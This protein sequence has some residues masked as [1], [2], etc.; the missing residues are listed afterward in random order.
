MRSGSFLPVDI[1]EKQSSDDFFVMRELQDVMN[2]SVM[3]RNETAAEPHA[4]G[5]VHHRRYGGHAR[6]FQFLRIPDRLLRLA[7]QRLIGC[8]DDEHASALDE[9]AVTAF[10]CE[11]VAQFLVIDDVKMPGLQVL[12]ARSKTPEFEKLLHIFFRDRLMIKVTDTV[13]RLA[14]FL[15]IG[16]VHMIRV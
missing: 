1:P 12:D 9:I 6:I 2:R 11:F 16:E 10:G 5:T 3:Q 4:D 14:Q 15:K 7:L 8:D 13:S